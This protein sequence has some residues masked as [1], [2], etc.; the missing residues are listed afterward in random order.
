MPT[1]Y[2]TTGDVKFYNFISNYYPSG[3]PCGA[4]RGFVSS[5]GIN[6]WMTD[7]AFASVDIVGVTAYGFSFRDI[8]FSFPKVVSTPTE[9]ETIVTQV[10][11][12]TNFRF[13]MS[14]GSNSDI[15]RAS[16]HSTSDMSIKTTDTGVANTS[17][18]NRFDYPQIANITSTAQ[19]DTY[20]SFYFAARS[21]STIA[22]TSFRT[23]NNMG[24]L[25]S[26]YN[27]GEIVVMGWLHN[28]IYPNPPSVEANRYNSCFHL[29]VYNIAGVL[30]FNVFY[31]STP[32]GKATASFVTLGHRYYDISCT[33]GNYVAGRFLT[34]LILSNS[35]SPFTQ[36][37]KV[38]NSVVCLGRGNFTKGKTYQ[39]VDVFGR[40]GTEY[41]TCV[42]SITPT[43]HTP[44]TWTPTLGLPLSKYKVWANQNELDYIMLRTYVE[45]DL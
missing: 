13:F 45:E 16:F 31:G 17:P 18:I 11:S 27:F 21:P 29:H 14:W 19:D 42:G 30:N 40:T 26:D 39:V 1:L 7:Y 3:V 35:V 24:L 36:I 15:D 44:P 43:T 22:I 5:A 20:N 12:T 25:D 2:N 4:V 38:D 32:I 23:K 9:N 8:Y 33:V 6:K 37:G 34:D 28:S 10:N 41:W